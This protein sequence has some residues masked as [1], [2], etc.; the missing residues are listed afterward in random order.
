M[1]VLGSDQERDG[2]LVEAASLSVPF[3]DAVEGGFPRE[4]EHEE[5]GDGV[6]ADERQ[7]VDEF[8]LA[9]EIPDAEGYFGV[10]DG[11]CFF[12]EV[13]ACCVC[14][15]GVLSELRYDVLPSVCI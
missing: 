10:A 15:Y 11:D 8:A 2:C 3:F 14:Y 9:A 7:H 4:V 1:V 5:D 6:V 12:H 13:D